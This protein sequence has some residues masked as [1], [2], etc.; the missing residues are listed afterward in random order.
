MTTWQSSSVTGSV[1]ALACGDAL[2][3]AV[4]GM[5]SAQIAQAFPLGL[6]QYQAGHALSRLPDHPPG[7]PTDDTE[8]TLGLT[9]AYLL[10]AGMLRIPTL[11][12]SWVRWY[13]EGPYW[14]L[15]PDGTCHQALMKLANGVSFLKSA[16][17]SPGSGS[18]MRAAP[19]GL[20]F[21][22]EETHR[23]SDAL[24]Q[25][26]LTHDHP[27]AAAGSLCMAEA[28]AFLLR[29]HQRPFSR[30]AFLSTL[31]DATL[32]HSPGFAKALQ[33]LPRKPRDL[34][35]DVTETV[36]AALSLFLQHRDDLPAAVMAAATTGG[37]TDTL[38]SM[39]GSLAGAYL[40]QDA[41][42]ASWR[43]GLQILPRIERAAQGI[44]IL[45]NARWACLEDTGQQPDG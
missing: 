3:A 41:I 45:G 6:D 18:A 22:F 2:G 1:I 16:Q 42:P 30:D 11:I 36:P 15:G 39:V 4:S 40:G 35:E 34:S 5:S 12:R 25:S 28:I 27:D 32:P 31:V 19:V 43:D 14:E 13:H 21:A 10:E 9:E 44:N 8:M 24:L 38:A 33:T 23:H 26:A 17:P 20:I 7:L 29:T 37:P